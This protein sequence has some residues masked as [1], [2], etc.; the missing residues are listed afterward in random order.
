MTTH[1]VLLMICYVMLLLGLAYTW[2]MACFSSVRRPV[3]CL[4]ITGVYEDR[5]A[6]YTQK[7]EVRMAG[8]QM[9]GQ[10]D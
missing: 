8:R 5:E 7:A 2:L 3:E 10:L 6:Y 4:P 1:Q 9:T